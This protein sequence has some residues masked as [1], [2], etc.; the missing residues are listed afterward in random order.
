MSGFFGFLIGTIMYRTIQNEDYYSTLC[1]GIAL[2]IYIFMVYA[3]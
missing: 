1:A 2:F 3:V